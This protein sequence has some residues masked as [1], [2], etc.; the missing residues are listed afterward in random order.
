[1]KFRWQIIRR[2][3]ALSP[4]TLMLVLV[5]LGLLVLGF[6]CSLAFA[7]T[8]ESVADPFGSATLILAAFITP[9]VVLLII[10]AS[11]MEKRP[12]P[13]AA[14]W[15]LAAA[16]VG[17]AGIIL[18]F[19]MAASAELD[20]S[21]GGAFVMI[22]CAPLAL[23]ILAPAIFFAAKAAPQV[24][25]ALRAER[26]RRTIEMI[27]ARGELTTEELASELGLSSNGVDEL[28][29]RLSAA[30][31]LA[32][33]FY[34]QRHR[35]YS[36]EALAEKQFRMVAIVSARGQ[37]H[38]RDL[39]AELGVTPDMIKDWLYE[40]VQRH[41]FTGYINWEEGMLYSLEA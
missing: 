25:A 22:F 21:E 24:R 3:F 5:A 6:G 41:R 16:L 10:V 38:V 37:I 40:L 18:G 36:A 31:R 11:M 26:E 4:S 23:A 14:L 8:A 19:G 28:L 2:Q 15:F 39:A 32:S 35:I 17:G 1:M 9:A 27:E 29:D 20:A 34:R 12:A 7:F 33:G 13:R 30:G